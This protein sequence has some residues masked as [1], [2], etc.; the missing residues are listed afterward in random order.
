VGA[1]GTV[2]TLEVGHAY[3][4]GASASFSISTMSELPTLV[5]V[6]LDNTKGVVVGS[7]RDCVEAELGGV[8]ARLTVDGSAYDSAS[9]VFYYQD[10]GG[11]PA[12]SLAQKWTS[13]DGMFIALDLPPGNVTVT[14]GGRADAAGPLLKL[15]TALVPVRAG[16]VTVVPLE[17]LGP[18]Q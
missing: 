4:D 16:A 13:G 6:A 9:D 14:S 18:R 1:P 2:E 3:N 7:Q 5:N 17:P 12:P 15:G 11:S 10:S 8:T